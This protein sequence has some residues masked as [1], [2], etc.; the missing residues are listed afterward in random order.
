MAQVMYVL[1]NCPHCGTT[2]SFGNV[3]LPGGKFLLRGCQVCRYRTRVALP[4]LRKKV[5]Y[6]DQFVFS[7][8]FRGGDPR[9]VEVVQRVSKLL[10][11]QM[12][13]APY[14]TV[15]EDETYQWSGYVNMTH[16]QLMAF[17][18]ETARGIQFKPAWDV[19]LQQLVKGFRAFL[20]SASPKYIFDPEDAVNGDVHAYED[21][22]PHPDKPRLPR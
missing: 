19:E 14:S 8:A 22:F 18:K 10:A 5:L 3:H 4:P 7:K 15:H 6:L 2:A 12:L 17:I 13:V 11:L 9:L 20:A 21:Y 16:T 1:N